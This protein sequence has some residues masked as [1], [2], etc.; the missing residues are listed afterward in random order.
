MLFLS[1]MTCQNVCSSWLFVHLIKLQGKF[2][3]PKYKPKNGLHFSNLEPKTGVV[4]HF[5]HIQIL[6]K[7]K[8][9]YFS[10]IF[11]YFPMCPPQLSTE[12]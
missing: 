9:K 8:K 3:H 1:A 7:T 10:A 5:Y 11:H 2:N 4:L 12:A 6:K